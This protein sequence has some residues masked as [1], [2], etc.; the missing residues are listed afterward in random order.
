MAEEK[1]MSVQKTLKTTFADNP[2]L[3]SHY[4]NVVNV[5]GG[6]EEFFLTFGTALPIEV[7]T[8]EDLENID[9]VQA[10]PLFRCV[11]TRQSMKQIL[12][13]LQTVYDQQT[14][15]LESLQLSQEKDREG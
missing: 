1:R 12:D 8:P 7:A 4:V 3:V 14:K 2:N 13:V 15:Q 6:I 10:Q 11:V 9:T 5:R